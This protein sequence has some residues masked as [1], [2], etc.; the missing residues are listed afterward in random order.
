MCAH[1]KNPIAIRRKRVVLTAGGMVTQKY[2]II[3][4]RLNPRR[5]NAAAQRAVE[6]KKTGI[7]YTRVILNGGTSCR[8][9]VERT[10]DT[11]ITKG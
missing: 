4:I 11:F 5:R 2:S 6:L 3:Y 7:I 8:G 10:N 1:V 9:T